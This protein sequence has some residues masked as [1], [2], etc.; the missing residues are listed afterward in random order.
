MG[1]S[2]R[3]RFSP[4]RIQMRE[5]DEL[6]KNYVAVWNEPDP[7]LRRKAVGELW[8]EE[9]AHLT[10]SLE[11]RGHEAIE[12]RITDAHERF[13]RDGD[14]VFASSDN[15]DGHHNIARFDWAMVPAG[16]GE[17]AAFGLDFLVLG[18]DGRILSDYQFVEVPKS[19]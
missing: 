6:V 3:P 9:G 19:S 16:G 11:A 8:A 14:F 7:A 18:D 12:A 15:A 4:G 10:E 13:V 1:S 5:L 17:A 2:L